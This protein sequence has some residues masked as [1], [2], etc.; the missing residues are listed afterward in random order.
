MVLTGF[1]LCDSGIDVT[2]SGFFTSSGTSGTG[3]STSTSTS[4]TST[5]G[6]CCWSS[7]WRIAPNSGVFV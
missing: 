3:T 7:N 1:A 6:A 2:G 4:G 5:S